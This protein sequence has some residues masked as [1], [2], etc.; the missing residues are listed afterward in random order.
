MYRCVCVC[1]CVCLCV[2]L[3]RRG[4]FLIYFLFN[5][6]LFSL[7]N[8]VWLDTLFSISYFLRRN[9]SHSH[10][11]FPSRATE[12]DA[13]APAA[14]KVIP[15]NPYK[16]EFKVVEASPA[17]IA[18]QA[19]AAA[20]AAAAVASPKRGDLLFNRTK[21]PY[22]VSPAPHHLTASPKHK[23]SSS[24]KKSMLQTHGIM[25]KGSVADAAATAELAAPAAPAEKAGGPASPPQ[26]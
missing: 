19:A 8:S 26:Q 2:Y 6:S 20:A 11:H 14:A 15:V 22:G 10:H 17:V 25:Y 24:P 13:A 7:W 23:W 4:T 16:A 21:S 9:W 12:S 5:L 18:P 3:R 1:V